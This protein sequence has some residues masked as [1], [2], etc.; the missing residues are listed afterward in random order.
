MSQD[1]VRSVAND[2]QAQTVNIPAL[3]AELRAT[4]IKVVLLGSSV[5]GDVLTLTY[6]DSLDATDEATLTA[7]VWDHTGDALPPETS[8]VDIRAI[9]ADATGAAKLGVSV[10]PAEGSRTNF[11]SHRWNDPTTWYQ[12]SVRVVDE[13]PV[14]QDSVG[15]SY[16]LANTNVIDVTHGKIFMEDFLIDPDGHP[17]MMKV[18]VDGVEKQMA[19]I[20]T[21]D[22]EW[23]MDYASGVL[24][25]I[26]NVPDG[27][28][29]EVTYHYAA[30]S[31]FVI[32]P[33][34]GKVL[35]IKSAEVQF[36]R[37]VSMRDT[38]QFE[39]YGYVA[40][41]DP[42]GYANGDYGAV[43]P[44]ELI[45][46]TKPS[47][48]KSIHNFLSE[49]NGVYPIVPAT[50]SDSPN[51]FRDMRNDVVTFPWE[52]QASIPVYS[53]A[54]MQIVVSLMNDR[55]LGGEFATST[56]YCYSEVDPNA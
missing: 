25:M 48:Y 8:P 55:P 33:D 53:S 4:D 17:Y 24:T 2:V 1:Y 43:P 56:F 37:N 26:T 19:D 46:A 18:K 27:S 39:F 34:P 30:D 28:T 51:D 14:S 38:V 11:I 12:S 50:S 52:Y 29:L 54:G 22:G 41:L 10:F 15:K 7:T 42:E 49:S 35:R 13:V 31:K 36:S 6:A 47:R 9:T 3:E 45:Y 16:Q 23:E 32:K 20:D 21:G 40:A 44:T 5:A